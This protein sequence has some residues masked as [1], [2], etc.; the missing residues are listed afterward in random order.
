MGI[1]QWARNRVIQMRS[2]RAEG[3]ESWRVL[4]AMIRIF[5]FILGEVKSHGSILVG[6]INI[7]K[8]SLWPL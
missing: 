6:E 7:F 4:E 1:V 3:A 5:D 2:E 8:G